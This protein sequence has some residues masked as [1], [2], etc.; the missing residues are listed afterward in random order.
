MPERARPHALTT[1]SLLI[2][3]IAAALYEAGALTVFGGGLGDTW[4]VALAGLGGV[5]LGAYGFRRDTR[6]LGALSVAANG[7]VGALYGFL[8][9][10]FTLGGSR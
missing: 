2:G 7:A 3:P 6:I 4:V 9:T 8:A 1:V 5:A 10:F